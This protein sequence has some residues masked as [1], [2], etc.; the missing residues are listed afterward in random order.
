ML[1]T[2]DGK[3]HRVRSSAGLAWYPDDSDNITD[4]LKLSDYAMYEA[5]HN[6]KGTMFEFDQESYKENAYLLENRE[7]INRL[8]DEGLIRFAFQP[9]VDLATGEIYAYEALMRPLLDNFQSPLEILSVAASQSKLN[10]LERLVIFTA[11]DYVRDHLDEIGQRRIFIN[12]IPSQ[13]LPPEDI[14]QM[15][16]RYPEEVFRRVMIE[17]TEDVDYSPQLLDDKVQSVRGMGLPIAIDDFG[18]G[19]SNEMRILALEPDVVKIDMG[20]IRG[21]HADPNKQQLVA[22]IVGFCKPKGISMVAEGVED[23][24]DLMEVTRQGIDYVQGYYTARPNFE[25]KELAPDVVEFIKA[26]H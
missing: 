26:M 12:S 7:A 20:I 16:Q 2:P 15:H 21:I 10:Q 4:L 17:I 6:R 1:V 22:N 3:A 23:A 9:I 25:L 19:Y 14:Q 8:L 18:S 24:E 5:K 13:K 11:F